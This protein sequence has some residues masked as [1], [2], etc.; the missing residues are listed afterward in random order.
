MEKI[1]VIIPVYKVEQYLDK[2]VESVVN[3]TYK[4]LEI[5]LVDDGS[6]DNC[7][8]MCDEWSTK[9]NR[10]K[11]IHK[12]NGGASSARNKGLDECS[13]DYVYFCDSDDFIESSCIEKLVDKIQE[14]DVV[15]MA[16]N[17]VVG[18]EV[19]EK[20][21]D[22]KKNQNELL[23]EII[24]EWDFGLLWN[25]LYKKEFIAFRFNEE[26]KIREDLLFNSEYFKNVKRIGVIGEPLYNYINNPNSLTKGAKTIP[27]E[28]LKTTH[29]NM[30]EL[31]SSIDEK[32]ISHQNASYLK[33]FI[34]ILKPFAYSGLKAEDKQY[35]VSLLKD[36]TIQ[37][38]LKDYKTIN[39][40]EKIFIFLLKHKKIKTLL[41]F[42]KLMK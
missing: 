38:A 37:K 12:E 39:L 30:V 1:S 7:P 26:F 5:I 4:N 9:D 31:L 10:I 23:A 42:I 34:N 40:K 28:Q 18:N 20:K 41:F 22:E 3:Q 32:L 29:L 35:V 8:K 21:Y 27:F 6:P 36:E 19:K 16:Y 24:H 33:S 2:C 11:V 14:N 17:I 13:G 15:I 25:K